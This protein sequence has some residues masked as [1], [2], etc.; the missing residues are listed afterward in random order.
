MFSKFI[1]LG[2]SAMGEHPPFSLQGLKAVY[3]TR[4]ARFS[5][6]NTPGKGLLECF[7]QDG[8]FY[9]SPAQDG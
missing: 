5:S 9:L 7:P 2:I 3:R 4:G 8:R 6:R 1:P